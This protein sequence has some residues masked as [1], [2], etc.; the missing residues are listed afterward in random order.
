MC[1]ENGGRP[2][3]LPFRSVPAISKHENIINRLQEDRIKVPVKSQPEWLT[4]GVGRPPLAA[5][6]HRPSLV[7][8]LVGPDV[9]WSVPGFGWSVW[10]GLWASFAHVTQDTIVYDFYLRIRHVFVLFRTCAHISHITTVNNTPKL[11]FCSFL[12]KTRRSLLLQC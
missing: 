9:R 3:I 12:S 5:I 4:C 1:G 2:L 10:S 7:H 6:G 8:C 11:A